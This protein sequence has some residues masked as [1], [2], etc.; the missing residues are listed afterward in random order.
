MT[1]EKSGTAAKIILSTVL[2]VTVIAVVLSC[3]SK[4]V[5]WAQ[6]A[7]PS[8]TGVPGQTFGIPEKAPPE[9]AARF[10]DDL[11]AAMPGHL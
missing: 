10:V 9:L 8:P 1:F 5:I 4:R 7:E 6:G 3:T 2:N 11:K